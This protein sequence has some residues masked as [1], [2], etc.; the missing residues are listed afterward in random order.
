MTFNQFAVD[1]FLGSYLTVNGKIKPY[2]EVEPR[3]YRFRL[4]NGGPSRFYRYVMRPA[5]ITSSSPRSRRA[6]TSCRCRR[7][8]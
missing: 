4:L 3:A 5:A 7:R 6:A 1:G 2:F 8:T